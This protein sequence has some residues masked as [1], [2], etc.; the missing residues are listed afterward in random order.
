MSHN[1]EILTNAIVFARFVREPWL[2]VYILLN[3]G[4]KHI[5][6]DYNGSYFRLCCA[7]IFYELHVSFYNNSYVVFN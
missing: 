4:P 1:N 7:G 2:V 5:F 3:L 6:V